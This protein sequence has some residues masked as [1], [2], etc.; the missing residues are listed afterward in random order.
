MSSQ[1]KMILTPERAEAAVWGGALLG[2]GGGGWMDD[3]LET[4]LLA[5]R[6]GDVALI[7]VDA[8][9]ESANVLTVSAVGAPGAKERYVRPTHFVRAVELFRQRF[10]IVP[11]ALITN[12]CGGNATIN[13]WLQSAVLGI[14][15]LDAPC[16]GRA[17]P[18]GIMGSMGLHRNKNYESKQT[19]A[20]GNPKTGRYLEAA[21][22]GTLD[23]VAG[24]IRT[25]SVQAGGLVAVA[26]NPVSAGYVKQHA[27]P[28][29]ITQCIDLGT[30]M[31]AATVGGRNVP[32]ATAEFLQGEIVATGTVNAVTIE[33][34]GG[35]DVGLVVM[36]TAKGKIEMTFWNEYMTLEID[37]ERIGTFPDLIATMDAGTGRPVNTAEIKEGQDIAILLAGKEKLI[38]GAGMRDPELLLTAEQAVNRSMVQY[39]FPENNK[40]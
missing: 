8:I 2:G 26:R 7:P 19:A 20:G 10:G 11:D 28:G 16:N 34:R 25:A 15:L 30:V 1:D 6:L 18:T 5:V 12:E 32:A 33:T 36:Q 9:E 35:F 3:G 21:V 38:L 31:L 24:L 39:V 14:P 37:G 27:A 40:L 4:A 17:H 22:S 13:G 23:N 29:A